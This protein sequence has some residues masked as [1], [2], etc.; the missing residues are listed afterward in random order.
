MEGLGELARKY[1]LPI[2]THI[3]ENLD[4]IKFAAKLFPDT[5]NYADIYAQCNLLTDKCI[6]AHCVHLSDEEIKIFREKKVSVGH[7]PN[8][9][10]NLQSGM[11]DVKRLMDNEINVG[12]GTDI[13]G[14]NRI[15]ILDCLRSALDVSLHLGFFKSQNIEGTG[16]IEKSKYSEKNSQYMPLN[17][18]QGLYLAT[19]GGSKALNLENKIGNFALGKEFDALIVDVNAQ[20]IDTFDLPEILTKSLTEQDKFDQMLQKF[21]YVGDDRN[22]VQV[23]VKG[24]PIKI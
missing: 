19:L 24:K 15:N 10:T 16:K 17:Y 22:I 4:E 7:C 20:P 11:C 6:M 18:K 23:Y 21:V 14:G 9:N 2:Q 13:S 8:S 3:C 12:L 1:K 5:K